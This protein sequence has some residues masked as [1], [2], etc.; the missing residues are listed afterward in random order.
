MKITSQLI[1][2]FRKYHKWIGLSLAIF[3]LISALTGF[4]LGWKK[5]VDLLQPEELVHGQMNFDEFLPLPELKKSAD[6]YW[7]EQFPN[8]PNEVTR[9]DVRVDK[10]IIKLL[11]EDGYW[12]AQINPMTAEVL[13]LERRHADWIEK[14]HDGSIISDNFKL[15]SMSLLGLGLTILVVTGFYLWFGPK[16]I[17]QNKIEKP[18]KRAVKK[19]Q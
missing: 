2:F 9:I 13:S 16:K 19:P 10:G 1:R 5:N 12:E 7:L 14:I 4:L 6:Q 18:R 15:I 17:K 8:E 11:F 3:L